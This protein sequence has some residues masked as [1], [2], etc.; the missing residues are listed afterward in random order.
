MARSKKKTDGF[1]QEENGTMD[2]A[3]RAV[4]DKALNDIVQRYGEG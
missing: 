3:R 4:L 2:E 1:S